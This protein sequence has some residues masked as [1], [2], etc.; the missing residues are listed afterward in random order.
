MK[1][2]V[3][4]RSVLAAELVARL[5]TLGMTPSA[6]ERRAGLSHHTFQNI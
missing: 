5:Q 3:T 6:F 4:F 1:T 2:D